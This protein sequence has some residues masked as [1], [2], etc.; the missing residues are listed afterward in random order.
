LLGG[1]FFPR[2]AAETARY[3]PLQNLHEVV[4]STKVAGPPPSACTQS[5]R[6]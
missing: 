3:A 6:S 5:C 2:L 1:Q 4:T